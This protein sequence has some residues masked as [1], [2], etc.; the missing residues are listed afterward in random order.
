MLI[1]NT[2]LAGAK[3]LEPEPLRDERGYFARVYCRNLLAEH[4]IDFQLKQANIAFNEHTLTLRGMHFQKPPY[5]EEKIVTCYLGALY[6]VIIDLNRDSPSFGKWY[7]VTLTAQNQLSLYVP[8]GFAH[9]YV[10]LQANTAIHYMVSEFYTPS[11]ESGVRWNDPAFSVDWPQ[12]QGLRIS[13]KD[14]NWKDFNKE[15]DS[16]VK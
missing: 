12:K 1:H 4:D 11:H 15:T 5:S 7:G 14:M 9:G 16:I 6:D 13:N 3:V 10:T 2:P 8:K